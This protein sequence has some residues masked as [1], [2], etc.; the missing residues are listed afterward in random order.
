MDINH[1]SLTPLTEGQSVQWLCGFCNQRVAGKAGLNSQS[2][3]VYVR[4]CP[5]CNRPT[6]FEPKRQTPPA[7]PGN[8]VGGLPE[9]VEKLYIEARTCLGA[10]AYTASVLAC[11][12][13]LMHI[14][15]DREASADLTFIE[16]VT[17]LADK[18]YVPPDGRD[19]VDHIRLK[20][21]EANH[22]IVIMSAEEAA[23]LIIFSEMLLKF[24]YEF[25]TL[26]PP[27]K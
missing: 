16:Y 26:L 7:V 9:D 21:N 3:Q 6:F 10:G 22:E 15:V 27:K 20:G 23:R 17:H 8:V 5:N 25:K 19:W 18:G 24:V 14:A 2:S 4:I 13:L 1:S 11:R 12:K